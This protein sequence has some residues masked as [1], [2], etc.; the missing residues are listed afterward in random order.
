MNSVD[1]YSSDPRIDIRDRLRAHQLRQVQV[2]RLSAPAD[3]QGELRQALAAHREPQN[4]WFNL[5][6]AKLFLQS[7][8]I[9]FVATFVF[10][11]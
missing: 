5:D 11:S 10:F 7:F 1:S 9:F 2:A 8:A 4:D 3:W 6:D